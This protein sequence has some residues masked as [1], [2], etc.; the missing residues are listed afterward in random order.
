MRED[1]NP[2]RSKQGEELREFVL[3]DLSENI[4]DYFSRA[5][6]P[7]TYTGEEPEFVA[8]PVSETFA[9]EVPQLD[10]AG[11]PLEPLVKLGNTLAQDDYILLREITEK[12][13]GTGGPIGKILTS[14][15]RLFIRHQFS[16]LRMHIDA[17][18]EINRYIIGVVQSIRD[19]ITEW[20]AGEG[21]VVIDDTKFS[22]QLTGLLPRQFFDLYSLT[23][24]LIEQ[25]FYDITEYFDSWV[26]WIL[27]N[28][29]QTKLKG[30]T[31]VFLMRLGTPINI[32]ISAT[33]GAVLR[34][35]LKPSFDLDRTF[36]TKFMDDTLFGDLEISVDDDPETTFLEIRKFIDVVP[37]LDVDLAICAY[38]STED[39]T[40]STWLRGILG[41][42]TIDFFG[43]AHFQFAFPPIDQTGTEH[44]YI[45]LREWEFHFELDAS[46]TITIW[47][48]LAPGPTSAFVSVIED[49]VS[50]LFESSLTVT[51]SILIEVTK[52]YARPGVP[53]ESSLLLEIL[54]GAQID[55]RILVAVFQGLF[56]IGFRYDQTS[57][58]TMTSSTTATKSSSL[59]ISLL[60]FVSLYLGIDLWFTSFGTDFTP[61]PIE[62]VLIDWDRESYL[63]SSTD[64]PDEDMDGL[65]DD[66]ENRFSGILD[67]TRADTDGDGLGDKLEL[68]IRTASNDND[69]DDD[70]LSDYEEYVEYHT[71]PLRVDTDRD[72]LTDYDEVII[73]NTN[74]FVM[75]TDF[76][77]LGDYYEVTHVWDVSL[78]RGTY[79]AVSEVEIGGVLYDDHTN[80]LN[81]DTDNDGLLDGEEGPNGI[82]YANETEYFGTE[83]GFQ[84][85]IHN[86]TH[87]LDRDTDD[88]SVL[89]EY[90]TGT[91]PSEFAPGESFLMDLNDGIEVRGQYIVLPDLDG[92]PDV[93]FVKTSPV[94]PDT[95]YDTNYATY[96]FNSDAAELSREPPSNPTDG[97]TDHDGLLDGTEIYGPGGSYTDYTN[98]DTDNDGLAD[99]EEMIL[100]TDPRLA[101]TDEDGVLDGDEVNVYHT[102]PIRNDTDLDG[103][104]DAE[105]LFF[106][107]SNPLLRDS[108][109]DGLS[110]GEEVLIFLTDPVY[111]DT[112]QDGLPDGFE[113]YSIHSNPL[114]WDTDTDGL[115]D[116]EEIYVY[117]TNPLDWDTDDD[118]LVL[119]NEYGQV[120][121]AWSDGDE[122]AYGTDPT[123]SDSDQDGLTDGQELY[124]GEGAES[125][126]P[127]PVDPLSNDTDL[128]GLLDGEELILLNVTTITY[129]FAGW[130]IYLQFDTCPVLNDTDYDGLLDGLEVQYHCDPRDADTD[131]DG[132]LDYTEIFVTGT[133]PHLN[134]T[135]GDDLIDSY[136]M[137][138]GIDPIETPQVE[139]PTDALV[140]DTD[141]DL[142]PDGLEILEYGTDP[143]DSDENSNGILDGYEYDYDGDGLSDG[144][145]F[146][147]VKTWKTRLHIK[148]V[149]YNESTPV[150]SFHLGTTN[151]AM[152]IREKEYIWVFVHPPGGFDNPD[153]DGDGLSDGDEVHVY[154]TDPT[155]TDSDGDGLSDYDE[156]IHGGDPN[157][158]NITQGW[159]IL[160]VIIA[161]IACLGGGL[162]IGA[163]VQRRLYSR[164]ADKKP[165]KKKNDKKKSRMKRIRRKKSE[166]DEK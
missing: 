88:D 4:N 1:S 60:L 34:L 70:G 19:E 80:P 106:F 137:C 52:V 79:G 31:P 110:D 83:N 5:I 65:T 142:L 78:T 143:L 32:G 116:G 16:G 119:P 29:V 164:D 124:L 131:N 145:E 9:E 71:D 115:G 69:T 42:F 27:E 118:S 85:V 41:R 148:Q 2:L 82:A 102:N 87:P 64:L 55:I 26:Q 35:I 28:P 99:Y 113:V 126:N 47:E 108:D 33:F 165:G 92:I 50:E 132:L 94:S 51:L 61:D 89:W 121:F 127:I 140:N 7:L 117:N 147:I 107:Y 163:L 8:P 135:D 109:N 125:F 91:T 73:Y 133:D 138:N 30:I 112:D 49:L 74:P 104:T 93:V 114:L 59:R 77:G 128:D 103:L 153:S 25:A 37:V 86:Y 21:I 13:T 56:R 44:A 23:D 38:L 14:L 90:Q 67:S 152:P 18:D 22:E 40:G 66:F 101:D 129:P 122:V 95:D 11:E 150:P 154:G 20:F 6:I 96:F 68:E 151:D 46:K 144:D 39:G 105:E 63:E 84:Y 54:I 81:P 72:N 43:S 141:G 15:L 3:N 166:G 45:S 160:Y 100:P 134:D 62:V 146:Y 36:F 161:T 123:T 48:F 139:Y 149:L 98:P 10:E 111:S 130:V 58:T 12:S 158:P 97:D 53:S 76:D 75:D 136:E 57:T 120:S 156:I 162:V 155:S 24:M 159:P 17:A 157:N